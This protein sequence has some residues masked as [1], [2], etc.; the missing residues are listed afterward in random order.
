MFKKISF[1]VAALFATVL[2]GCEQKKAAEPAQADEKMQAAGEHNPASGK[3]EN[4]E[5]GALTPGQEAPA[6]AEEAKKAAQ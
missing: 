6:P 3:I 2:M 5:T 1:L 4:A